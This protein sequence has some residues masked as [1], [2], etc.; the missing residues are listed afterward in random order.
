MSNR[1]SDPRFNLFYSRPIHIVGQFYS[2][3]C[4]DVKGQGPLKSA[5]K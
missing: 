4:D 2:C 1:F 3:C 5:G